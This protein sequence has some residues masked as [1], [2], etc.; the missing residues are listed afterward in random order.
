MTRWRW[1]LLLFELFLIALIL[2][3]PQVDLPDFT[4][5]GGNAPV[6]A[7]ARVSSASSGAGVEIA[8]ARALL[9][10]RHLESHQEKTGIP[11]IF[12]SSVVLSMLCTF[13]C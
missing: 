8:Q 4:F 7:K 3:L 9:P 5:H 11:L 12:G 10:S 6:A 2:V 1:A 13:L